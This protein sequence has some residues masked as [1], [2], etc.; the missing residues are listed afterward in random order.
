[1]NNGGSSLGFSGGEDLTDGVSKGMEMKCDILIPA[2]TEKSIHQDN[3]MNI[4][5]KIIGEAA[6][7][8]V[9]PRADKYLTDKGVVIIPDMLLNAGGVTVSY[10]EWLKNLEHQRL[11][12]M[13]KR[14]EEK[15]WERRRGGEEVGEV[16]EKGWRRREVKEVGTPCLLSRGCAVACVLS[17]SGVS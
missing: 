13:T 2:A 6:N 15:M 16:E 9:T 4:Q 3:C 8:P 10:F 1:M 11:G 5:A 7:G 12:R 14:W 17:R